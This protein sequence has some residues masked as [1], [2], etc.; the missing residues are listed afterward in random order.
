MSKQEFYLSVI[1]I[2]LGVGIGHFV[3][4]PLRIYL[5]GH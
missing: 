2:A 5:V 1:A 4:Q 3:T